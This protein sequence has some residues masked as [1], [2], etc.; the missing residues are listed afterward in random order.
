MSALPPKAG[1]GTVASDLRCEKM[2]RAPARPITLD[3]LRQRGV[4]TLTVSCGGR[5][6]NRDSVLD[7]RRYRDAVPAPSLLRPRGK[8]QSTSAGITLSNG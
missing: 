3:N 4:K 1:M 7:L 5:G 8:R 6:L 2:R